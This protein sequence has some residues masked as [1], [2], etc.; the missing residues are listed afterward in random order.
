MLVILILMYVV[1]VLLTYWKK[2]GQ[3]EGL[4]LLG[5]YVVSGVVLYLVYIVLMWITAKLWLSVALETFSMD[6]FY[7]LNN[8]CLLALAAFWCRILA[9]GRPLLSR[10][11]IDLAPE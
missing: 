2:Y 10:L 8:V 5:V 9:W 1:Y 3:A 7:L 11:G 6:I 4:K